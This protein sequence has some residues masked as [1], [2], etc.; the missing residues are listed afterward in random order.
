MELGGSDFRPALV[1]TENCDAGNAINGNDE[2]TS[3]SVLIIIYFKIVK[4]FI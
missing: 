4:L 1:G 2:S 3:K